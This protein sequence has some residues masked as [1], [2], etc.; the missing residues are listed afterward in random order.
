MIKNREFKLFPREIKLPQID[1]IRDTLKV[2]DINGLK[3]I[4]QH[5]VKTAVENKVFENGT[6]DGYIVGCIE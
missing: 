3:Q 5:I 4:N 1:A 2:V 6:I